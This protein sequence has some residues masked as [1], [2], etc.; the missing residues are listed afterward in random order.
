MKKYFSLFVIG[1]LILTASIVAQQNRGQRPGT[2][3]GQQQGAGMATPVEVF[4][5]TGS[6]SE[7]NL[8]LGQGSPSVVVSGETFVL[9]PY[10][11]LEEI[12][13]TLEVGDTVTITYFESKVFEG[14]LI[15]VSITKGETL[16]SLRN[17]YGQP[18]WAGT[19]GRAQGI[20]AAGSRHGNRGGV[21]G[22][23][24]RGGSGTCLGQGPG[25]SAEDLTEISGT[26][27]DIQSALG[28]PQPI[29]V[30]NGTTSVIIGPNRAWVDSSF[31]LAAGDQVTV[32]YFPHPVEDGLL[33]AVKISKGA[34]TI[35]LRDDAGIPLG[36]GRGR[37]GCRF[38][39]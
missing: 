14:Q 4:N 24:A 11:Y 29:M 7:V 37:G 2:G 28:Q 23:G 34:Q 25:I 10:S 18:L 16:Y 9:A 3:A 27:T 22:P 20:R 8:G 33:V 13:L 26:V 36:A 35:T 30:L 21:S 15:I 38:Q 6:I 12:G 17:E 19:R 31:S 32:L 39:N 1:I 5:L